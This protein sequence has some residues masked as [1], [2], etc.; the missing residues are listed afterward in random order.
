MRGLASKILSCDPAQ[1]ETC[2]AEVVRDDFPM[3]HWTISNFKGRNL[4]AK[5]VGLNDLLMRVRC[6]KGFAGNSDDV[7]LANFKQVQ[8]LDRE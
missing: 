6:R 4:S 3:F 1:T 5:F 2:F 8:A 7:R